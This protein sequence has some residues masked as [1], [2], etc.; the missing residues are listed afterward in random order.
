VRE[1]NRLGLQRDD[2]QAAAR[3]AV[4]GAT[5]SAPALA[6]A[7]PARPGMATM[8]APDRAAPAAA[9]LTARGPLPEQ[10]APTSPE[11][12][13]ADI[14]AAAPSNSA[15][16]ASQLSPTDQAMFAKIRAGAP[17]SI[18]DEVVAAAMLS[19]KRDNIHDAGSIAQV[20]VANG[21]LWVGATTPGF[22]GAAS[23]SEPPPALQDTLRETQA[24]NREQ[25]RAQESTQRNPDDPS[26]G[27]TR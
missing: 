19:A 21:K 24:F 14:A 9:T 18:P 12:P 20:G 16:D 17:G 3:Q 7:E 22:Y 5:I 13:R 8:V 4:A 1:A 23:L 11:S 26:R 15:M 27:P 2:V 6:E 25:Q 10:A